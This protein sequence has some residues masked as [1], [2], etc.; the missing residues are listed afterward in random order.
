MPGYSLMCAPLAD[1]QC[2]RQHGVFLRLDF[3][4]AIMPAVQSLGLFDQQLIG[5]PSQSK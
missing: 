5:I 3:W 1:M 2:D 4:P